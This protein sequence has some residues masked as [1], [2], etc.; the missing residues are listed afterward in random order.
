MTNKA[1]L[2]IF[3]RN[4]GVYVNLF[5]G[6]AARQDEILL[7]LQSEEMYGG[8]QLMKKS[9]SNKQQGQTLIETALIL[10]LILLIVLG[11]AEF[12]RA[13]HT[14]NSI[15][16]AARQGAR[17]AVVTPSNPITSQCTVVNPPCNATRSFTNCPTGTG[18]ITNPII[19]AICNSAGVN[20]SVT[21]YVTCFVNGAGPLSTLDAG[22]T[23][24]ICVETNFVTAVPN[25]PGLGN[26]LPNRLYS[27][28]SMRYE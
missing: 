21:R 9:A 25:F 28:A 15:K 20:R 1:F 4:I 10:F 13:W 12:A 26:I 16:N 22:D 17:V 14:K 27:D 24:N 7:G 23:V 19:N 6:R 11:I 8:D 2:N 18:P 5:N 3:I